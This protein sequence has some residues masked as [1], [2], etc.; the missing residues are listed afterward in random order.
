MPY[1][2][3]KVEEKKEEPEEPQAIPPQ[4]KKKPK[5]SQPKTKP[6]KPKKKVSQPKKPRSK[7]KYHRTPKYE[8]LD[9][10]DYRYFNKQIT[11]V[12]GSQSKEKTIENLIRGLEKHLKLVRGGEKTE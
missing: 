11:G 12:R 3:F 10:V 4:K 9:L 7:S 2:F 1:D 5:S 8:E 6:K